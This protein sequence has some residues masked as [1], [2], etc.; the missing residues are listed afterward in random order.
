MSEA[1]R[2]FHRRKEVDGSWMT[3]Q[4]GETD[5]SVSP[6]IDFFVEDDARCIVDCSPKREAIAL[7][8]FRVFPRHRIFS[9]SI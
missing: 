9:R 6:A 8:L 4:H 1:I 7:T 2:W 5:G 3:F